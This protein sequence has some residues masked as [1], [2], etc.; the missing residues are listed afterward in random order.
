[1]LIRGDIYKQE[2]GD[3]Y[4]ALDVYKAGFWLEILFQMV[5]HSTIGRYE[6]PSLHTA[7]KWEARVVTAMGRV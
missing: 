2:T 1:M 5:P 7:I 4:G 3:D 6:T